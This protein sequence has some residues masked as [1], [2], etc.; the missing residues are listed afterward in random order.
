[1]ITLELNREMRKFVLL[2]CFITAMLNGQFSVPGASADTKQ[3]ISGDTRITISES[4]GITLFNK[5]FHT[6]TSANPL[7]AEFVDLSGAATWYNGRY[8]QVKEI[9]TGVEAVGTIQTTGGSV[10]EFHDLYRTIPGGLELR[11]TAAILRAGQGETGFSTRVA[12]KTDWALSVCEFLVPGVIYHHNQAAP[13]TALGSHPEDPV[14]LIRED[15]A[16]IPLA[17]IWHKRY[18]EW[19]ELTHIDGMADTIPREDGLARLTNAEFKFGS[20]AQINDGTLSAGFQ[21]PGTEGERTYVFGGSEKGGRFALRSHPVTVGFTQQYS[22]SIRT[23]HSDSYP[24][25]V[26]NTVRHGFDAHKAE[27]KSAS[28]QQVYRASVALLNQYCRPYHGVVGLPFAVRVPG[29]EA[30]DISCQMGFVG[31]ALPAARLLI[32]DSLRAD[33][34]SRRTNA[35]NLVNFWVKNARTPSGVLKTWFDI[36]PD[37]SVTW[38]EYPQFLRVASDGLTAILHAWSSLSSRG[39]DHADWMKFEREWADWLV[40]SQNPD[41]SWYRSWK[42]NGDPEDRSTDTTIQPVSLLVELGMVTGDKRYTEAARR[43][44]SFCLKSMHAPAAY[45][46]GTPDNPNTA[47]KEAC[48][49]AV[50]GFLSL[51]D[52]D[53]NKDWLHAAVQAA[54][55]AESWVYLRSIAMPSSDPDNIYPPGRSTAGLSLIALGHSGVDNFMAAIP[56]LWYRLYLQTKETHFLEFA[57]YIQKACYQMLDLDG[58]L[59]YA[60]PG[61]LTEAMTLAPL[62]GHGVKSWLPW[63]SVTIAEP[64]AQLEDVFDMMDLTALAKAPLQRNI[65]IDNSFRVRH[66]MRPEK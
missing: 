58:S 59:H 55:F 35:V 11:R 53:N 10:V 19:I 24:A 65:E 34:A 56:F 36:H 7:Q 43:A 3:L 25:L 64:L 49:L 62:R 27:V 45:V 22:L 33:D 1:M 14:T 44:G 2:L 52:L 37:G 28:I 9:S 29:G 12:L 5:E 8:S 40:K 46:G 16:A 57:I 39:E 41:G 17:A 18:G 20:V 13:K 4:G 23:G 48:L 66:G 6:A 21:Y 32:R 61:L 60:Y 42:L 51:Y 26:E 63:L 15:R 31:D 30:Y 47:D 38:R 54:W 50:N